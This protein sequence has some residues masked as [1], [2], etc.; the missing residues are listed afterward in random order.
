[1]LERGEMTVTT[2]TIISPRLSLVPD[3][4]SAGIKVTSCSEEA[5]WSLNS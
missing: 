2:Q 3:T 4:T 5:R 1:M